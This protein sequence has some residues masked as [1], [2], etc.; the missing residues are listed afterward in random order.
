MLTS[1]TPVKD[2]EVYRAISPQG[3]DPNGRLNVVGLQKD[4]EFYQSQGWIEAKVS[5]QQAIDLRF[6]EQALQE[7]GP[8]VPV[9]AGDRKN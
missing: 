6:A 7:L 8:Y 5:V 3:V 4:L 9:V 2:P 1:F